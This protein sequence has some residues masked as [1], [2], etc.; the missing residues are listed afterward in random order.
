MVNVQ[1]FFKSANGM[2]LLSIL[3]G[4]G[5]SGIFKMT[6]DERDCVVFKAAD[7]SQIEIIKYGEECYK[8]KE[9]MESCESSKEKISL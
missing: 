3:L 1:K 5:L 2:N 8:Y 4:L 7:L 6:C 9:I